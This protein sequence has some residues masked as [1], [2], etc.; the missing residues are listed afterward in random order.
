MRPLIHRSLVPILA[1][2]FVGLAVALG[3]QQG[4]A[5]DERNC[6]GGGFE[7]EHDHDRAR[8]A[9]ECG[10]VMPL[11]EVLA[12]IRPQISG[13][14]VETEFENEDGLWVY[15]LKY[16]D[17]RGRLVEIYVDAGTAQILK[18]GDD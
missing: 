5:D 9:L 2:F 3:A 18:A 1:V 7:D 15:E 12:I 8:R 10:E 17:A 13:E 14:I 11:A 6:A 4:V 16:I